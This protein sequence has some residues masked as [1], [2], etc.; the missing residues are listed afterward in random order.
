MIRYIY[1]FKDHKC[2]ERKKP[3]ENSMSDSCE[4][5]DNYGYVYVF[6]Q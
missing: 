1:I 5:I 3:E 2:Q 6:Q 4:K